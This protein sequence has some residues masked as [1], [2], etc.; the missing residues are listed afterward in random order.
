MLSVD[1]THEAHGTPVV[2]GTAAIRNGAAGNETVS[3]ELHGVS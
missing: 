3:S 2:M 1:D